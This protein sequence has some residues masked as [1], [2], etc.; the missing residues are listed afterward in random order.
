MGKGK[1]IKSK[2]EIPVIFLLTKFWIPMSA[3]FFFLISIVS[4]E[5]LLA[6]FL[7]N[8]SLVVRQVVEYGS[9]IGLWLSTAFL[10][11]RMIT[12][13]IWDGLITG[14]SGRPVPRLPK[15]VTAICI[16]AV[17]MIGILATVFDQSVTGIW[18]TSGVVSIVIGIALRNVILDVFI[19]LSMHVEQSF[20]IGEWVMVHQ[21]R[22]ETHIVGQVV[23]IN[24]R[25][26]RLKTTANNL[27][28]VPNS[29]MGEAI[30]TNYMRP[31]PH[32][33][34]DLNFVLDYS[35]SP[36]RAIR[37]LMSGVQALAGNNGILTDPA[38]EIRLDEALSGGQRYEVRFFILPVNISP[39]E[40]RHIVNKS[41]IEHLARSGL[42]PSMEKETVFL[43]IAS[44]L[45]NILSSQADN[46]DEVINRSELFKVLPEEDCST[47]LNK[48]ARKDLKAGEVLYRQGNIGDSL[49]LL[50][51]GLLCSSVELSDD[52]SKEKIE[53]LE[54]GM[55]FG[56]EAVLQKVT[57]LS[58]ISAIT[59]SIVLAFDPI[60]VADLAT[61]NG[62]FLSLLN[63]RMVLWQD[64][65]MKTK[66]KIKQQEAHASSPQKKTG[67][68]HT[69]QTFFT[70]FFPLSPPPTK[71]ASNKSTS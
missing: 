59:D 19:G 2:Q 46:F 31:D 71:P 38:P 43:D 69:I 27:V 45:P 26:T 35:V 4:K 17:A 24:W 5:E 60:A 57:R 16:F 65:I 25:T 40:S 49:F 67:V 61:R 64:R 42:T 22:R 36:D 55:H 1:E 56:S 48:V 6:R 28:V 30:L 8:A 52:D 62:D 50:V 34:I 33:R 11:Q 20:R 44:S 13:F 21:N 58:T 7:G 68:G 39:N 18:A 51:E 29:K 47:L 37:I 9:Q 23:E 66:W 15:D 14:I 53:R 41:V 12:V 3:F 63:E 32:F 10:V 70:D 54:S